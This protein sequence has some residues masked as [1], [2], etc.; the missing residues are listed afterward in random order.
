MVVF[1][2]SIFFARCKSVCL[3]LETVYLILMIASYLSFTC[4]S[5]EV[6]GRPSFA[7]LVMDLTRLEALVLNIPQK[8][9]DQYPHC[10]Q[11]GAPLS[12][13]KLMY[14][15]VQIMYRKSTQPA[16]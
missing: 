11:L 15:N 6:E 16:E 10:A 14:R 2:L 8:L 1:S 9:L 13:G 12:V 3:L 4:R 7:Q 5:P